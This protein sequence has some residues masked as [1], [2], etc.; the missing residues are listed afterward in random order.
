[1]IRRTCQGVLARFERS[2][3]RGPNKHGRIKPIECHSHLGASRGRKRYLSRSSFQLHLQ[4]LRLLLIRRVKPLREPA[5]HRRQQ[6]IGLLELVLLLPQASQAG[7]G[8]LGK[9]WEQ[10]QTPASIATSLV[11]PMASRTGEFP[12][13]G[14][15]GR[16]AIQALP[17]SGRWERSRMNC[18]I[19][20]AI[21]FSGL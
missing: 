19:S 16:V 10:S 18:C 17:R 15:E 5:R 2:Q 20:L 12:G 21:S 14:R 13:Y 3:Q 1:M 8:A 6:V 4:R 7:G 11:S 9:V